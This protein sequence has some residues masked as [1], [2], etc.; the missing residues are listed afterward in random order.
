M[1]KFEREQLIFNIGNLKIGG[2]PGQ[3]PTLLIGS[4]F[5]SGQKILRDQRSGLFDRKKAEELLNEEE[6]ISL[7]LGNPRVLDVCGST[8]EAMVCHIDFVSEKTESPFLLDCPTSKIGVGALKHVGEVGL[9]NRAIYNSINYE[10]NQ[11]ELLALKDAEVKSAILLAFNHKYPTVRGR[12]AVLKG[13]YEKAGLLKISEESGIEKPLVDA[14]VID[15][16]DI[17]SASKAIQM[18]KEEFGIPA[19]CGP[20]NS[21]EMWRKRGKLKPNMHLMSKIVS[22]TMPIT[23]GANFLLYGPIEKAAE[24]YPACSLADAY[25]SYC[26]RQHYQIAPLERGHPLFR[27]FKAS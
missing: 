15:I 13:D 25:V 20:Y 16:P 19:G 5:Y 3:L 14:S 11:E 6:A 9:S 23:L 10:T 27:V 4:I 12:I 24:V 17:G 21:I 2:Q 1:F 18:I 22:H 26:M 7:R 8:V